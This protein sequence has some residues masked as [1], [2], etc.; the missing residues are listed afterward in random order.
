MAANGKVES[1]SQLGIDGGEPMK[2]IVGKSMALS[3]V[4]LGLLVASPM[5][6]LGDTGQRNSATA[7]ASQAAP[8]AAEHLQKAVLHQLRMLPYYSVFDNLEFKLDGNQVVLSGQVM[9]PVLKSDAEAAVKRVEG[10]KG[11][12]NNI[13]VLPVSN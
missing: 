11:V 6:V 3:L 9:R 1:A 8:Q 12:I 7:V 10:V 4:V 5:G 13:E 2:N